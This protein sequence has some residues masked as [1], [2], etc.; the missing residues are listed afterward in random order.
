MTHA[1]HAMHANSLAAYREERPVLSKRAA[2]VLEVVR[3]FGPLTDREIVDTL[4]YRDMNAI[5]PRVTELIDARLLV[6]HDRV[7]CQVTGKTV[8]RVKAREPGEQ[9]TLL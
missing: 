7:R 5:R 2:D 6:E 4:G 8:R 9:M 1:T 3:M